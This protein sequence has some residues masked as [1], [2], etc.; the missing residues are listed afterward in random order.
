MWFQSTTD[1]GGYLMSF[2]SPGSNGTDDHQVWMNDDGQLSIR[3]S[4]AGGLTNVS[5]DAYNDGN[6]HYVVAV[7]DSSD[8]FLY[9]DGQLVAESKAQVPKDGLGRWVV[10]YG[11]PANTT[12]P[13][14]SDY[15]AGTVSDAAF[16]DFDLQLSQIQS[17]YEASMTGGSDSPA[18]GDR[19]PA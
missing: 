18:S 5:P 7:A 6:W 10:G 12:N 1:A 19:H 2:V 8:V 4:H 3:G 13:P 16:S 11:T 14:S 15:F 17:Q 9:V